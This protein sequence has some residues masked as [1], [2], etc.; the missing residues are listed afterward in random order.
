MARVGRLQDQY[1]IRLAVCAEPVRWANAACGRKRKSVSFDRTLRPPAGMTS[2]SPGKS[3]AD[4][5]SAL[6]GRPSRRERGRQLGRKRRPALSDERL[7][8][9]GERGLAVR[10]G[11]LTIAH[12]G[13]LTPAGQQEGEL[14]DGAD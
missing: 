1:G 7:E 5:A 10:Q 2:R 8:G 6:G 11:R 12:T 9:V 4:L 3:A 13:I 14:G